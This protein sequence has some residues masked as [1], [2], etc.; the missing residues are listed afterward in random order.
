MFQLGNFNTSNL[1]AGLI[2]GSIGLGAF[3]CGKKNRLKKLIEL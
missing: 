2:F 1:F 3:I